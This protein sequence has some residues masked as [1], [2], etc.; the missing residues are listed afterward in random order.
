MKA[1]TDGERGKRKRETER[2]VWGVEK[3]CLKSKCS[4]K[5]QE[6]ILQYAG[7]LW[8]ERGCAPNRELKSDILIKMGV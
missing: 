5:S 7:K 8:E 4:G 2:Q 1:F 3:Q 6:T